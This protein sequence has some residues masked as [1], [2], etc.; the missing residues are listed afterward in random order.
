MLEKHGW[1]GAAFC[2]GSLLVRSRVV[3]AKN[4]VAC[5]DQVVLWFDNTFLNGT[6]RDDST[7][8]LIFQLKPVNND[9]Q[10]DHILYI[11]LK[12][13]TVNRQTG[14]SLASAVDDRAR[15]HLASPPR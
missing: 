14:F 8:M 15:L 7:S 1:L 5:H 11:L 3:F 9:R 13:P 6:E 12:R 10:A 4:A 2:P